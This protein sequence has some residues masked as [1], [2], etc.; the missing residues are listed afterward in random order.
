MFR[1][2]S[3]TGN[4]VTARWAWL[5]DTAEA[6][7]FRAAIGAAVG[8]V[9]PAVI[10]ADWRAASIVSPEVAD[11][12]LSMLRGANP[13]L[14]RSGILLTSERSAFSLQTER[15]VREAAHPQRRTFR[16]VP[17]LL[18]WLS[19]VLTPAEQAAARQFLADPAENGG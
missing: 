13:M 5:R 9:R 14:R 10:C 6:E 7:R 4:L 16:A 11:V 2:D 15:L 18:V 17:E 3:P 19:E 8:R 1:V 12:M